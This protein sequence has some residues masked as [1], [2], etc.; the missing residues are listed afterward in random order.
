MD[1][2]T[3]NVFVGFR[4]SGYLD[5]PGL[6]TNQK[7]ALATDNYTYQYPAITYGTGTSQADIYIDQT[8]ELAA[9]ASEELNLYDGSV[10]DV[11]NQAAPLRKIKRILIF[12][13]PNADLSTVSAGLTIGNPLTTGNALW[14]GNANDTY[15]IEGLTGLPFIQGSG[16]GKVVDVTHT[17]IK[18]ANGSGG[19]GSYRL[20]I[21][22]TTV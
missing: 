9:S 22:G 21:A 2:G 20:M 8:R 15:V 16:A 5:P 3:Q 13:V 18:I 19:K 11:F 17:N 12:M 7:Q 14:F 10:L 6:G 1:A 4:Y